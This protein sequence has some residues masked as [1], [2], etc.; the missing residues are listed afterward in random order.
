M[1]NKD[2]IDYKYNGSLFLVRPEPSGQY[3]GSGKTL[4]EAIKEMEKT[5]AFLSEINK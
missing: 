1:F 2:N 4:E 5:L 3:L